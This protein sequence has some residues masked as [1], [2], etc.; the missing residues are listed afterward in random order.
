MRFGVL[1]LVGVGIVA[2]GAARA[3]QAGAP[4]TVIKA[5]TRLVLVDVVVTDKK[6]N[7]ITDL[8]AKDFQVWEDGKEQQIA[9][10]TFEGGAAPAES[11][12]RHL[13]FVFDYQNMRP[14]EQV[15]AQEA[16]VKFIDANIAPNRP[17]AVATFTKGLTI[18]PFTVDAEKL[19]QA[20]AATRTVVSSSAA[21]DAA[22]MAAAMEKT[23]PSAGMSGVA[24]RGGRAPILALRNLARSLGAL[25]GRK[26]VVLF[27][28]GFIEGRNTPEMTA[29]IDAF[30]RSNVAIYPVDLG[31][32]EGAA[33]GSVFDAGTGSFKPL[34]L[35]PSAAPMTL[36]LRAM[37]ANR[38]PANDDG[39][40]SI[41]AA[42]QGQ[43]SDLSADV[44]PRDM[45]RYALID[46]AKETGGFV[47]TA[48]ND[49]FGA[50]EKIGREQDQY[51]VLSYS[52]PATMDGSCHSL[53]VK[54]KRGG[55]VV[56]ARSRYCNV[57]S[58]DLLAGTPVARQLEA[59][60]TDPAQGN[61]GAS[62]Q[63][64]FFYSGDE[65]TPRVNVVVDIPFK[66]VSLTKEKGK[67]RGTVSVLGA[68]YRP[69]GAV[70]ARFSDA[71]KLELDKKQMEALE[72]K[73]LRYEKQFDI[74]PGQY[75]LKLALDLG[76][77]TFS[78]L[79]TPLTI[80][81]CE[82]KGIALASLALSND[83]RPAA[84]AGG[85]LLED[86]TPLTTRGLFVIPSGSH[87][88]KASEQVLIYTEVFD[89]LLTNTPPP[90]VGLVLKIKD[91]KTGVEKQNS[92]LV[93]VT[94]MGATEDDRVTVG[95]NLPV[96]QLG[97]G[98]YVLEVMAMDSFGNQTPSRSV[99]L[100]IE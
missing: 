79:E 83:V 67:M 66:T 69:D 82:G 15:R 16:A 22:A 38:P 39:G 7:Y 63:A 64:P 47:V 37:Q 20:I 68:A 76:G 57:R 73:P 36:P 45:P 32:L 29:A 92:G 71:L 56:R 55:A 18:G 90:D 24:T 60:L 81:G 21:T 4:G 28:P 80:E 33:A 50:V 27:S 59:K 8:T 93:K 30:N 12:K 86:R 70:A 23:A 41:G 34:Q 95:L 17:M 94:G 74:A 53:K 9:G 42:M 35:L 62:M 88:F 98:T 11:L 89:A 5:E 97:P 43:R 3:Q 72:G 10:C 58:P 78:R 26:M 14:G 100:D 77:E 84:Q 31:G 1:A 6:G 96:K 52:A 65:K 87:R 61:A 54:V 99:D 13:V 91:R 44:R 19:R 2:A 25:P 85:A 75:T 51:Y 48:T 46:L 49:I 40:R